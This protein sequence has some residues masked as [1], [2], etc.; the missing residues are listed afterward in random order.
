VLNVAQI[1]AINS[2]NDGTAINMTASQFNSLDAK[3][4][5]TDT[6]GIVDTSAGIQ[7]ELAELVLNV[8]QI[9]A[10][11]STNDGTA[12]NMTAS[13][14]NSLD[15]LLLTTDT[16]GVVDTSAGI[17][18]E[19]AELV[20]NLAQI[21]AI[22]STNDATAINMTASQFNSLDGLL[23]T[24]D[25]IGIVDTSAAIEAELAELVLNVAQIDAIN[26]TNDGTAI[27]MTASQFNSLDA[28]LLTTDTIGV[29]DTSA[30][31]QAELAELVLNVAQIDAINSTNDGTAIN[32]DVTQFNALTAKLD[33]GDTI[34]V[35]DS[36][37][38]ISSAL[39]A[40]VDSTK[41]DAIV[42]TTVSVGNTLNVLATDGT[43]SGSYTTVNEADALSV[44]A[45]GKWYFD[46]ASD[47]LT[48]YDATGSAAVDVI[49]T[50]AATVTV[51]NTGVVTIAT[52]G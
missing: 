48:I 45:A 40:L 12:I 9:D 15:D 47:T 39:N 3:L 2:T 5:T 38:A 10:I 8:A 43:T 19:L 17:Q 23:L 32:V 30:G 22:N 50:G 24:S 52:L 7:A 16:V 26:S 11:N 21:D 1:D 29:V 20:L 46:N 14:F 27:N 49:L 4:L 25:T 18:A 13:Q 42:T 31:I 51:A 36:I 6:I 41:P 34:K 44:N 28:K 33:I 37:S 35:V